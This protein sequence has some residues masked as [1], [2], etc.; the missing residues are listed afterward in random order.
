MTDDRVLDRIAAWESEG[1][2]DAA[3]AAR[4]RAAEASTSVLGRQSVVASAFGPGL[5]ITEVFGYLGAAFVLGAWHSLVASL[6]P[7]EVGDAV[8]RHNVLR[9]VAQWLVAAVWLGGLGFVLAGRG[10]RGRR[11]AGVLY[12]VATAHVLAGVMVMLA[13]NPEP[14]AS[15]TF[16]AGAA[17]TAAALFFRRLQ[18]ALLTQLGLI[19]GAVVLG[20]GTMQLLER[21]LFGSAAS[22]DTPTAAR[23]L[24]SI[25]WWLLVAVGFGVLARWERSRLAA[26]TAA[27]H[28]AI[29]R[30]AGMT[31]L[32]A[33]LTAIIGTS[34]GALGGFGGR[35][36]E[37]WMDDLIV[38]AVS[39]VLLGLAVRS[40]AAAY[41][42]P[43][44]LGLFIAFSDL[45]AQYVAAETGTGIALLVEG[46][47]LLVVGF[48]ADR[49]RRRLEARRTGSPVHGTPEPVVAEAA[50]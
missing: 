41:L 16:F 50:G 49:V 7:A 17:G 20:F 14:D 24:L 40:G 38:A 18:P 43:A 2:I 29:R 6:I 3:T 30:R 1:I 10:E 42:Y 46:V 36:F 23:P 28:D 47:I 8:V 4:L 22:G 13:W 27:E 39:A 11:A 25:A 35:P 37:P 15:E 33:G 32:A 26:A 31:A 44:A 21:F 34:L 5:Q 48:G 19:I 45:N 9:D 12:L